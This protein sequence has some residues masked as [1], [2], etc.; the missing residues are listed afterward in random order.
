MTFDSSAI[1]VW[2]S[3]GADCEGMEDDILYKCLELNLGDIT[4]KTERMFILGTPQFYN[5]YKEVG[6]TRG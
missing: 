2:G 1:L 4:T 3:A 6:Q 5:L